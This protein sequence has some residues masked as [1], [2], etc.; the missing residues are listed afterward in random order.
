[1]VTAAT[2]RASTTRRGAVI[3]SKAWGEKKGKKPIAR[4]LSAASAGVEPR[5]MGVGP[6]YAIPKA[7]ER[8]KLQLKD[9]DIIEINEA[10]A[11]QVLGCLKLMNV[12]F[13][14]PRVNPNGGA[15]AI[16][17]PLGC[18]GRAPRADRGARAAA[19]R[20]TLRRGVA[21]HRRRPGP[22]RDP[23]AHAMKREHVKARFVWEDLL[24]LD[25]QL[26]EDERMVREAAR[27]YCQEKLAPRILEAF[28]QR[29][30]PGHLPRD[31]RARPARADHSD[32]V[33]RPGL[34]LRVLRAD[35]ARGRARR[36]GLPL[37]DE[38]AVL[39]GHAADLRVRHRKRRR[40]TCRSS[41]AA[42]GSAASA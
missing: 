42:N 8:A 25:Q 24:L 40:N 4:I 38:R 10:F 32:R 20:R 11:S 39:A 27:A 19:V 7:L 36:L 26:T 1:M 23:G 16:G 14:D 21:V 35:R 6:A 12:D 18:L 9:M 31:G 5:I 2:P 34:E 29:N 41:P 15:I 17:H 28:R 33:R 30:R 3:G 37:D 13:K 22:R